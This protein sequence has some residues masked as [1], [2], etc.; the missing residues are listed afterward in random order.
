MLNRINIGL[1]L[2]EQT[3]SQK[4]EVE[5]IIEEKQENLALNS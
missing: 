4:D 3:I 1:D 5:K 2:I